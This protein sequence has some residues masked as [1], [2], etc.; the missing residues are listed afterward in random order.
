M[1]YQ[2]DVVA[3]DLVDDYYYYYYHVVVSLIE[4]MLVVFV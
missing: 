4:G 3:Y 1:N 2:N